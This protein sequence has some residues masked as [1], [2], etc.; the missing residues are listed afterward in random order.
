[1]QTINHVWIWTWKRREV[2]TKR[3]KEKKMDK[4]ETLSTPSL[5]KN[6]IWAETQKLLVNQRSGSATSNPLA[7]DGVKWARVETRIPKW[8]KCWPRNH[9]KSEVGGYGG[10]Q[11]LTRGGIQKT[12]RSEVEYP[13]GGIQ[14]GGGY[15]RTVTTG[16]DYLV[17]WDKTQKMEEKTEVKDHFLNLSRMSSK[18]REPK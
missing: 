18:A 4:Q 17:G 8:S 10:Y 11:R 16:H 14:M 9:W 5:H 15:V 2:V 7:D 13:G 12:G 6:L 1:M 3:T